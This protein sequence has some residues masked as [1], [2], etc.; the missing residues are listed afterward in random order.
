MA[1]R[2][3]V[4]KG[5]V[6]IQRESMNN[7]KTGNSGVWRDT[8]RSSDGNR[9]QQRSEERQVVVNA[10]RGTISVHYNDHVQRWAHTKR[11]VG[12]RTAP[13]QKALMGRVEAAPV[14]ARH[15]QPRTAGV[16]PFRTLQYVGRN[17]LHPV[18]I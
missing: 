13:H 8:D 12:T 3:G 17:G 1:V 9:E 16:T 5:I 4:T 6:N 10:T 14:P 2:S 11:S 18:N 15:A 7:A